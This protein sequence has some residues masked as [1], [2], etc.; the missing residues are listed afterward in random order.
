MVVPPTA[1]EQRTLF[2]FV[3]ERA[4]AALAD[5]RYGLALGRAIPC[6]KVALYRVVRLTTCIICCRQ[7]M[8]VRLG[9]GH[10]D[11]SLL[12]PRLTNNRWE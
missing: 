7:R 12:L 9:N 8:A 10:W 1:G 6:G 5:G 4:A 3:L 2:R 11:A